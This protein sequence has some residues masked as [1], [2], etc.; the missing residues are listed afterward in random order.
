[1]AEVRL[2]AIVILIGAFLTLLTHVAS[3]EAGGC[4]F[5]WTDRRQ[6]DPVS[7]WKAPEG[8][9]IC[10]VVIET[11]RIMLGFD[12]DE[13]REGYCVSGMGTRGTRVE[14]T[15]DEGPLCPAM[16][17]VSYWQ[18]RD[19]EPTPEPT[20]TRTGPS[21][22]TPTPT[23]SATATP[24]VTPTPTRANTAT[25]T[26]N[27]TSAPPRE[28]KAPTPTATVVPVL[29]ETGTG[30][31]FATRICLSVAGLMAILVVAACLLVGMVVWLLEGL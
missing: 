2:K 12:S 14:R 13:C 20:P 16:S 11:P 15:C 18:Q 8:Y 26:E 31:T 5:G 1:M 7:S 23:A 22:P 19:A 4:V 9:T 30:S 17:R 25:P 29:P 24:S 21:S 10:E 3:A 28:T 27:P 6:C